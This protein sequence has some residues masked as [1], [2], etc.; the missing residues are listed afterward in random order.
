MEAFNCPAQVRHISPQGAKDSDASEIQIPERRHCRGVNPA[1]SNHPLVDDARLRCFPQ[2]LH[3]I[4][5][6][7]SLFR[8]A[9]EDGAQKKII[10]LRKL[11]QFLN[12]VARTADRAG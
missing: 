6:S 8:D 11:R 7:V 4:A 12:R 9:L 5:V 1:Q 2:L 3:R 10:Q